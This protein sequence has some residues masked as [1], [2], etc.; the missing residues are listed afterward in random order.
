MEESARERLSERGDGQ[1]DDDDSSG[2]EADVDE[3]AEGELVLDSRGDRGLNELT[4][5]GS[6]ADDCS[7]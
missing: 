6:L 4:D 3:E 7:D 1:I 2:K 5:S